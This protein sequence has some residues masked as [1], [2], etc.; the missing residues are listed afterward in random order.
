MGAMGSPVEVEKHASMDGGHMN[1]GYKMAAHT[2]SK[3]LFSI[4]HAWRPCYIQQRTRGTASMELY[5][6]PMSVAHKHT[7]RTSESWGLQDQHRPHP[8]CAPS[9]PLGHVSGTVGT[10]RWEHC[11]THQI[12]RGCLERLQV[13]VACKRETR[14]CQSLRTHVKCT[15]SL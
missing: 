9:A 7:G 15:L 4:P 8:L 11:S 14:D 6:W 12:M 5:I 10:K 1:W 2:R 3:R 13:V